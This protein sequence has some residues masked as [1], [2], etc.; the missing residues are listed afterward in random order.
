M[1]P[2]F[3]K[4][5]Y[6][7][8]LEVGIGETSRFE[9]M[10]RSFSAFAKCPQSVHLEMGQERTPRTD[11]MAASGCYLLGASLEMWECRPAELGS[12]GCSQTWS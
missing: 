9:E 2:A 7:S 8:I 12:V 6:E 11:V 10:R 1:W 3:W 4:K 5:H